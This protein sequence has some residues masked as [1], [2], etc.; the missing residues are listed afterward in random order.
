VI[1]KG[2]TFYNLANYEK[3]VQCFDNVLE[4]S[5]KTGNAKSDPFMSVALLYRGESKYALG[6]YPKALKDFKEMDSSA[7]M[8]KQH[9][10]IGLCYYR[11]GL[12]EDAE[13]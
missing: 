6:D 10:N 1:N 4:S 8:S 9:M 11:L 7:Y 2:V 3:A 13:K 12:Y 5:K